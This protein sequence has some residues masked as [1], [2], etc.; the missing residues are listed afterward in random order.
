VSALLGGPTPI[1]TLT[2]GIG[3]AEDSWG[4]WLSLGRS[5]G[6][7]SILDQGLFR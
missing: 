6:K 3:G 4:F 1:G 2:V 7:G 5:V